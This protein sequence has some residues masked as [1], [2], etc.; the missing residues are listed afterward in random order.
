MRLGST[1]KRRNMIIGGTL[2][3]LVLVLLAGGYALNRSLSDPVSVGGPISRTTPEPVVSP[4]APRV[5]VSA[6]VT[7][8][9]P[10]TTAR[11]PT[12]APTPTPVATAQPTAVATAARPEPTK[13]SAI[14]TPVPTT[15]AGVRAVASGIDEL[16]RQDEYQRAYA[17]YWEVLAGAYLRADTSRLDEVLDGPLLQE[18][19]RAI[20]ALKAEGRGVAFHIK[21]DY[22]SVFN[23][24]RSP[25][26]FRVEHR[27]TF[28]SEW[29]D[30]AS[31]RV[32]G[33]RDE[34]QRS[35]RSTL[36]IKLNDTWKAVNVSQDTVEGE[37]H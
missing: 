22:A 10:T 31:G 29:V 4:T 9:V 2:F 37:G 32:L 15:R 33:I 3:G 6:T 21:T 25:T 7:L 11:Q 16:P 5:S 12:T 35:Q 1:G 36:F 34:R 24:S 23:P 26:D 14:A 18:T 30:L 13:G 19:V 17:R 28:Y 20:R 27:Y 8:D